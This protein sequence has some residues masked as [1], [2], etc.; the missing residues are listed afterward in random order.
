MLAIERDL[1]SS[2]QPSFTQKYDR[3]RTL[4]C[5]TSKSG[6]RSRFAGTLG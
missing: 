5:E 3:L 1:Q 2:N 4:T 6:V